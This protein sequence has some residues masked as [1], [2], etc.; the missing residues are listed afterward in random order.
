[1]GDEPEVILDIKELSLSGKS[2]KALTLCVNEPHTKKELLLMI[3]VTNQTINV[4]N[5]I[6]PLISVGCLAPI[7][8]DRERIKNVRYGI[9]ARGREYLNYHSDQSPDVIVQETTGK[10]SDN[11]PLLFS[12][13]E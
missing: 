6:N 3:G 11:E 1:M 5:I 12:D 9:T 10:T 8:E 2:L 4:R 7:D 13:F